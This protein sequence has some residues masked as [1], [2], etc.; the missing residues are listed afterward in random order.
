MTERLD[1]FD[2]FFHAGIPS[3]EE[4]VALPKIA[5]RVRFVTGKGVEGLSQAAANA[6]VSAVIPRGNAKTL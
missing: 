6:V 5:I 4:L 1:G 3:F 2:P